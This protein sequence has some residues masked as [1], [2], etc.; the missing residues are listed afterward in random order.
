MSSTSSTARS[1]RR[2]VLASAGCA[3]VLYAAVNLVLLRL[4]TWAEVDQGHYLWWKEEWL[5]LFSPANYEGR[6]EG[7]I[8]L[9]GASEAREAFLP[10]LLEEELPGRRAYQNSLSVGTMETVLLLLEYVERAYGADAVPDT[11]VLGTTPR[12]LLNLPDAEKVPLVAAIDRYSPRFRVDRE[13]RPPRLEPAGFLEGLSSRFRLLTKQTRRFRG[14][15]RA[16]VRPVV[17]A[18]A[19]RLANHR[20]F[21]TGLTPYK[22]H[23]L[24]RRDP[25]KY[26]RDFSGRYSE[27]SIEEEEE[28]L[29]AD[30]RRL[31]AYRERH[32]VRLLVVAMPRPTWYDDHFADEDFLEDWRGL[33]RGLYG[34]T[35]FLDLSRFLPDEEFYDYTHPTRAGGEKITREIAR[36]LS[37]GGRR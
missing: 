1:R 12:F 25:A 32:G 29:R 34:G 7:R 16:G 17:Q 33:L 26:R 19:P 23:H 37:K 8:L 28:R 13:A 18:F 22:Y 4:A 10:D 3:L 5:Q 20:F 36:V 11:I 31:H 9:T 21:V 35:G 27:W 6:G 24:P 15:V 30:A 2:L 14:A